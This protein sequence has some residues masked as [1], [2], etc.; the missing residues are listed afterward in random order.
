M[1]FHMFHAIVSGNPTILKIPYRSQAT[2]DI[3]MG[4]DD[5]LIL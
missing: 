3:D 1:R 4:T 2:K 5:S